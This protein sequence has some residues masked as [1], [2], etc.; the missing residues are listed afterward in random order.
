[1]ADRISPSG[2]G[3]ESRQRNEERNIARLTN[4]S[5]IVA[6]MISLLAP[7]SASIIPRHPPPM[8]QFGR[9]SGVPP[10]LNPLLGVPPLLPHPGIPQLPPLVGPQHIHPPG[11]FCD[12]RQSLPLPHHVNHIL[13]VAVDQSQ[14]EINFEDN[15]ERKATR[16]ILIELSFATSRTNI[17]TELYQRNVRIRDARLLKDDTVV[18][19]EFHTIIESISF[20]K[21]NMLQNSI[22]MKYLAELEIPGCSDIGRYQVFMDD[23][24]PGGGGT[25]DLDAQAEVRSADTI[26]VL[27]VS[28]ELVSGVCKVRGRVGAPIKISVHSNQSQ[29]NV[30]VHP[31]AVLS[32]SVLFQSCPTLSKIE[33]KVL[34]VGKEIQDETQIFQEQL[35]QLLVKNLRIFGD[36]NLYDK[37][38]IIFEGKFAAKTFLEFLKPCDNYEAIAK[39]ISGIIYA[40]DK[41]E[42]LED[43]KRL[44]LD[45]FAIEVRSMAMSYLFE[46]SLDKG[47]HKKWLKEKDSVQNI[48]NSVKQILVAVVLVYESRE[49]SK[50]DKI[51][52]RHINCFCAAQNM[53][54]IPNQKAFSLTKD[55]ER[56]MFLD[57]FQH[58]NEIVKINK[59]SV[60]LLT[61]SNLVTLSL[62]MRKALKLNILEQFMATF[63][64]VCDL[65][66]IK[67]DTNTRTSKEDGQTLYRMF[68]EKIPQNIHTKI[69]NFSSPIDAFQLENV[70]ALSVKLTKDCN[71]T[72]NTEIVSQEYPVKVDLNRL[73]NRTLSYT[74]NYLLSHFMDGPKF[75]KKLTSVEDVQKLPE[76]DPTVE[77]KYVQNAVSLSL[78][79]KRE[80]VLARL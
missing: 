10:V 42:D 74:S 79:K 40:P 36:S 71:Q 16:L 73:K 59:L 45:L 44:D 30:T 63:T 21:K 51:L 69:N 56:K 50:D 29:F 33:D 23:P 13:P 72:I 80:R 7:G 8:A 32:E 49:N 64:N 26:L 2:D 77:L 15:Q 68:K 67:K 5:N 22:S 70:Q 1:M 6:D 24:E 52:I 31:H 3:S 76:I 46:I 61:F 28:M 39:S 38:F 60:T 75:S 4:S 17:M 41:F 27:T 37:C 62:L 20:K 48:M 18:V 34:Y 54:K 11:V 25:S 43:L 47:L 19:L 14:S 57:F 12:L 66:N 65:E 53:R 35:L 55:G 58:V 78:R 9:L